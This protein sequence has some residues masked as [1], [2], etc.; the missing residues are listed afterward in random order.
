MPSGFSI[1]VIAD[2]ITGAA[3]TGVQFCPVVG[4]VYMTAANDLD[5]TGIHTDGIAVFTDT[6]NVNGKTAAETV[7]L[8]GNALRRLAPRVVYKKIDSCLRGNVGVE[9]ETLLQS[10][11][12]TASFVVPALPQQ[13]RTTVDGVHRINEIPV[14]DTEIGSDPLC[15]VRESRLPALLASQSELPVGHVDLACI[16]NGSGAMASRVGDL[17]RQGCRHITFD[18]HASFHLDAISMF[19]RN[20]FENFLLVGSA[21][22]AASVAKDFTSRAG[23]A[24]SRFASADPAV[25]VCLWLRFPRTRRSGRGV[26]RATGWASLNLAPTSLE[27]QSEPASTTAEQLDAWRAGS[28]ILRIQPSADDEATLD[29][30]RVVRGLAGLSTSLLGDTTTEGLFLSG[31][32]TAEAVRQQIGAM[33]VLIHEEIL[34]G[35]VRGTLVGGAFDGLPVVTKAGAFGMPNTLAELINALK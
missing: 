32:D 7:R 18:A 13:G 33:A 2:D 35:L 19:A 31:G 27:T 17:L 6:R 16:E 20:H 12:M 24:I 30:K 34:P 10:M 11:D 28:L 5:A 22:L 8:A 15:P 21:G 26:I 1:V 29:P 9:I 23:G 14:A 25:V 3:D 4:P